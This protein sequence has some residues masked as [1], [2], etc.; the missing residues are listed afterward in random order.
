MDLGRQTELTTLARD[1]V[2]ARFPEARGA[3]LGG[4]AAAG[5]ANAF[6]DLDIVVVLDGPPAPYRETI[7]VDGWPVE[8][9]VH[10]DDSVGY[11]FERER[12]QGLCVLAQMLAAGRG[13]LGPELDALQQRARTH[14]AQGPPPWSARDL[15]YRRYLIS[16]ALDDLAGARDDDE[17]DAVAGH[18]LVIAAEL[19]LALRGHWQGR[20]KWLLRRLRE[21]DEDL[22]GVLYAGHRD[23]VSSGATAGFSAACD[24]ILA[25]LGGRLT[26]GFAVR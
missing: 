6:S 16:D 4:S 19:H 1:I 22:A 18:L 8:L 9:F 14:I 24:R 20:G 11:W 2:Q 3:V 21:C 15:E 23:V 7:R 25:P 17:R 10:T 13:L 12:R 26:E 5:T